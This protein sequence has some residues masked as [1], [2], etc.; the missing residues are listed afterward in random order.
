M[1]EE[2]VLSKEE[3]L[4]QLKADVNTKFTVAMLETKLLEFTGAT[5]FARMNKPALVDLLASFLAAE[6]P[7]KSLIEAAPS[8]VLCQGKSS[9][10][11][12]EGDL[13]A[14][15]AKLRERRMAMTRALIA[16]EKAALAQLE[17]EA[18]QPSTPAPAAAEASA[19]P[20]SSGAT[21]TIADL[22]TI[23]TSMAGLL[24]GKSGGPRDDLSESGSDD[25]V[26]HSRGSMQ[27]KSSSGSASSD[28]Q[29]RRL[30]DFI[31]DFNAASKHG[32]NVTIHGLA[33]SYRTG[34]LQTLTITGGLLREEQ[35]HH[36]VK[37]KTCSRAVE[38]RA[39]PM[40]TAKKLTSMSLSS[41]QDFTVVLP[42]NRAE[43]ATF[44]KEQR[45]VLLE[46][47]DSDRAEKA[48]LLDD[49]AEFWLVHFGQS[50]GPEGLRA[51]GAAGQFS[52]TAAEMSA[53]YT[54][55]NRAVLNG[56]L[57]DLKALAHAA[58]Q[59]AAVLY[60]RNNGNTMPRGMQ[61]SDVFVLFGLDCAVIGCRNA[62]GCREYC[63]A[64]GRLPANMPAPPGA[65]D[66]H[67][68]VVDDPRWEPFKLTPAGLEG[69]KRGYHG[70]L[71]AFEVHYK[72]KPNM[73]STGNKKAPSA[74]AVVI[75]LAAYETHL[76]KAQ[77]AISPPA[78]MTRS[79]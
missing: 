70:V 14:E 59:E 78:S 79:C 65:K 21:F 55:W 2:E 23:I 51:G 30:Q 20:P 52:N 3:L 32:S 22:G 10:L 38:L 11:D 9:G 41:G 40:G 27:R 49:C 64:C 19:P 57:G 74:T 43:L 15:L 58:L 72:C 7:M 75:D 17:R 1:P 26:D 13:D 46:S 76:A 63:P 77:N 29:A 6:E 34:G 35:S 54:V 24:K 16:R 33:Q 71:K 31:A 47:D 28:R 42:R 66:T 50:A 53:W 68:E 48:I 18:S 60:T 39:W 62:L 36:G 56:K 69:A 45:R 67:K 25:G 37:N 12:D 4:N 73:V 44:I 8:F 61:M 5:T